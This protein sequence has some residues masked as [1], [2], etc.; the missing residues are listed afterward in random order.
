MAKTTS[1]KLKSYF[2]DWG[3]YVISIAAG[4]YY[5]LQALRFAHAVESFLDESAYLFK[6]YLFVTG[7]YTPYQ[8]YGPWTNKLPLTF[9]IQGAI[10]KIFGPGL[11][12][13]R[14]FSIFMALL[15]L[16]G[17]W[18]VAYRFGGKWWAAGLVTF[19]AI[20]PYL[21]YTYSL[22]VSQILV[23]CL[24]VWMLVFVIGEKRKTW[25]VI[26]GSILAGF[27]VVSRINMGF[28]LPLLL[29][30]IYWEYG[31]RQALYALVASITPIIIINGIYWP[32]ILHRYAFILP[33]SLTPFLAPWRT[34]VSYQPLWDPVI[35]PINRALSFLQTTRIHFTAILGV[36]ISWIL[37]PRKKDWDSESEYRAAVFLSLLFISLFVFHTWVALG[38][39]FCVFCLSGYTAFFSF[40][41]LLLVVIV[42]PKWRKHIPGWMQFV[43][44]LSVLLFAI[45]SGFGAFSEIGNKLIEMRIPETFRDFPE[46]E[47]I[48]LRKFLKVEQNIDFRDARRLIP[49]IVGVGIGLIILISAYT[50]WYWKERRRT[51]SGDTIHKTSFGYWLLICFLITGTIIAPLFYFYNPSNASG[52]EK[53]FITASE[54]VGIELADVIPPGSSVYWQAGDSMIPLLHVPGV[55]IYPPQLNGAYSF[56]IEGEDETDLLLKLG[57]WNSVLKDQWITEADFILV[58]DDLIDDDLRTYLNDGN[59]FIELGSTQPLN[60]CDESTQI[61][62]YMRIQ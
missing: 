5:F 61:R 55:Q 1:S 45:A 20:N 34:D 22:A 33:R 9:L 35:I 25:Q 10:Q 36:I 38:N 17:L 23:A 12:T 51:P 39:D 56:K 14:Y 3:A 58:Q 8:E 19:F 54:S 26:A 57:Y 32:D 6:G 18:L 24:L 13:G 29:L 31:V 16:L 2:E 28:V 48:T 42:F 4:I 60:P 50:V 37:W 53:S 21:I 59:T 7:Q 27:I 49:T 44:V 46:F 41:G 52:C 15:L 47:L 43:L 62:I 40:T 11:G 30:Y